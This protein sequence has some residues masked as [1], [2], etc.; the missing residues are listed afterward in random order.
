MFKGTDSTVKPPVTKWYTKGVKQRVHAVSETDG[1]VYIT[2][3][4]DRCRI[5]S[6]Y[7]QGELGKERRAKAE[8]QEKAS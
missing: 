4:D 3:S 7:Y 6:D 2:L 8:A 1:D 5:E